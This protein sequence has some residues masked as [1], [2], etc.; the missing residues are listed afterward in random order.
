MRERAEPD[1]SAPAGAVLAEAVL[2]R[3]WL[4]PSAASLTTLARHPLPT[5]WSMLRDDPGAVLQGDAAGFDPHRGGVLVEGGDGSSTPTASRPEC[6]ADLAPLQ[7]VVGDVSPGRDDASHL[8]P[9]AV[10]VGRSVGGQPPL[11]RI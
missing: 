2:Q 5:S 3:A 1:C 7:A 10:R 8:L 6:L 4:P 11:I 9:F